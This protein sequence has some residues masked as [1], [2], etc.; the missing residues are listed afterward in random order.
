MAALADRSLVDYF[1]GQV[2]NR[3]A[4]QPAG[5]AIRLSAIHDAGVTGAGIVAI[6]DTGVDPHHPLLAGSL[7]PG[8]DFVQDTEGDASEWTDLD[9][10]LVSILDGSTVSIL[11]RMS[12]GRAE[13]IDGGDP[14]R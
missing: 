14:G 9:G 8:Y 10:S 4:N 7:V 1:G 3:Y 11:D 12:V 6:I 5:A 13:R 2:W